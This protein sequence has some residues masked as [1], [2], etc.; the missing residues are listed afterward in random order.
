MQALKT[1]IWFFAGLIATIFLIQFWLPSWGLSIA[2]GLSIYFVLT[3][4]IGVYEL[5]K[6]AI[7]SVPENI[8]MVA[9]QASF[10]P[11][12]DTQRL[13]QYT[14]ELEGL[15]FEKLRE[16]SITSSNGKEVPCFA[17]V[18]VH[19]TQHC[20]AEVGQVFAPHVE[21]APL[22]CV[23]FTTFEN[24]GD[25]LRPQL[26]TSAAPIPSA[27]SE[28]DVAKLDDSIW[29]LATS[30]RELDPILW[31]LRHPR[32]LISTHP[33]ESPAGL[34]KIHLAKRDELARTLELDVS[35]DITFETFEYRV[36][37]S[38]ARLERALRR[39]NPFLFLYEWKMVAP[40]HDEWWGDYP[41]AVK[42]RK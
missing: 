13:E 25:N 23:I 32:K 27:Q 22:A 10:F 17:R 6:L 20:I 34:F 35:R 3:L 24:S 19:P 42:R 31:T 21:N 28:A 8:R 36:A 9:T 2:L 18:F 15:G 26:S 16:Y 33:K 12:L 37:V 30:S 40:R 5:K 29:A 1:L 14:R 38:N 4:I 41:R 7:N 11:E 39:K